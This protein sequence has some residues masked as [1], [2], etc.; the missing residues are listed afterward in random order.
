MAMVLGAQLQKAS[1][2]VSITPASNG[3]NICA[4]LAVGGSTPGY[5]NLGTITVSE[6]NTNDIATGTPRTFVLN[7]PAGWRFNTA[8][9]PTT[10][11]TTGRNIV[12]M[13]LGGFTAT[14]LTVNIFVT[15]TGQIDV[16]T[17]GNLQVQATATSSASGN[18]TATVA[19][20]AG[21]T[22]GV[23]NFGS[24]S[25]TPILTPSVAIGVSPSASV[26]AGSTVSFNAT[27]TNGGTPT[28]QWQVNG[29]SVS[30]ATTTAYSNGTLTDGDVVSVI[31]GATGCVTPTFATASQVMTINPIPPAVTVTGA[32]TYCDSVTLTA[33]PS[34]G[35]TIYFQ[36]TSFNGTSTLSPSTSEFI[37]IQGSYTYYFRELSA[38]GCWGDQGS[39]KVT[40][41]LTPS[42]LTITPSTATLCMGDSATFAASAFAPVVEVLEADFNGGLDA[43]WTITNPI[44]LNPLGY[45]A[46]KVPPAHAAATPGDG[47]P[48]MQSSPDATSMGTITQTILT[49]PSFSLVGYTAATLTFN[50]YYRFYAPGD[51]NVTVDYSIDG[52]GSWLPIHNQLGA[53]AGAASWDPT[54]P[55]AVVALPADAMG[56]PDVRLRW[57]YHS[58]FGWYWTIDNVKVDGA[59]TLSYTWTGLAGASGLSC[60][61]CDT[62]TITP[63]MVG[64]NVYSITTTAGGCTAGT[65]LTVSVNALPDTF[66][67]MGGGAYCAGG[68]GVDISLSGSESDVEYQLYNG[69][70]PMGAP[71]A[72]TGA[73]ISFG[74]QTMAGT[75]SVSATNTLTGCMRDMPGTVEVIINPLPT[76]FNVMGDATFCADDTGAHITMDGSEVGVSYQLYN[77][78]TAIGSPVAGT[79]AAL[80]LGLF[81]A[82]GTYSVQATN[83][84]TF[85][86]NDMNG[87]PVLVNNALPVVYNVTGGGNYCADGAGVLVGLDGSQSTIDYQLYNGASTVG[88][89]MGGTGT[90][91]DFGLQAAAGTYT[92][93]ATDPLTG[94]DAVMAGSAVVVIDPVPVVSA[95]SGSTNICAGTTTLLSTATT[96]GVWSSSDPVVAT[97]GISGI[98]T[99]V[100]AGVVTISYTV[101]NSLGCSTSA[102]HGMTI[103]DPMPAMGILPAG[104]SITLCG[105]GPANLILTG[106]TSGLLY[107]WT[108]GG[109]PIAGETNT[110]YV[111]TAPGVYGMVVDNGTCSVTLVT[112]TVLAAPVAGIDLNTSGNFLYTGSFATYQWYRNGTA[113]A[114]ATSSMYMSPSAG[115]YKVVVADV[116]G[117]PDTS[118]DYTI[119]ATGVTTTGTAMDVKVYPNP[120]SATIHVDAP[121]KVKL[122]VMSPDGRTVKAAGQEAN[123]VN[124]SDLP[125][126][127]YMLLIYDEH[128]VLIKTERFS[129]MN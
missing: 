17:V 127:T 115:T 41:N 65:T 75:Y 3:T 16:F 13:N 78:S 129:K 92:V 117:C 118:A 96:G 27:P 102:T 47:T 52:G 23:T 20:M 32:G 59:S 28:Y 48:Y 26:C 29:V 36:G 55:N 82:S 43:G 98:V 111:A 49:S 110:T 67:V 72:G 63:A 70:A 112:K 77:G 83:D 105:G 123:T 4:N 60:I 100:F 21:V 15:G 35:G 66:S 37:T 62:V 10:G 80:D 73:A 114:G 97:V 22:S 101:T 34:S 1:A 104:A 6:G 93:L 11:F 46:P 8:V 19:G 53:D 33:G 95:I 69:S 54:V 2:A 124:V 113:I 14:S 42:A 91:F 24:L 50:Q 57:N 71:M 38:E 88:L 9:T 18:I 74:T 79:G 45:W 103:G 12:F 120:A 99:G 7:A 125:N 31:M 89:P 68:A 108:L 84:T 90:A 58:N 109:S 126:G 86:T 76:V 25:L 121:V 30:G 94:C 87:T 61:T 56:E 128:S 44:G 85:C 119:T 39:A 106:G 51:I 5:T 64:D 81:T 107:Q 40:I 116:N 122:A